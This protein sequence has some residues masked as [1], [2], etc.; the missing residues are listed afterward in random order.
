MN[1]KLNELMAT[2]VMGWYKLD[3]RVYLKNYSDTTSRVYWADEE[4]NWIIDCKDWN[5]SGT[6]DTSLNQAMMCAN[7]MSLD[8]SIYKH[9]RK[10][11]AEIEGM[12]FT[13]EVV[14]EK[15]PLAICES[16]AEVV[17]G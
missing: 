11:H 17:Q 12:Y 15:L 13:D 10:W 2:E 9:G 3:E 14:I 6:D 5:P 7:E 8:I 16:I 4:D 1:D